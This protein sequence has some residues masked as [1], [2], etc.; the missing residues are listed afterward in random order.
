MELSLSALAALGAAA[1]IGA[2]ALRTAAT[3]SGRNPTVAAGIGAV[4][5]AAGAALFQVPLGFCTF[6]PEATLV[7]LSFGVGLMVVGALLGLRLAWTALDPEAARERVKRSDTTT[8]GV[9]RGHPFLPWLLLAP[10]LTVLVLFLYWPA[11]RTMRLS[12][13]NA[14]LGAP[15]TADRCVTNFTELI[16]PT[17]PTMVLIA[18]VLTVA[19]FAGSSLLKRRG[20]A[21]G[22]RYGGYLSTLG[23]AAA[24]WLLYLLWTTGFQRVYVV[25]LIISAGTVVIGLTLSLAV[26]YLAYRPIRGANIYRTFLVWPYAVSPPIAGLIFF[27]IFDPNAG[28]IEHWLNQLFGVTLPNYRQ[29]ATLAQLVVIVASVWK[30]L[31]YNLLFYIAGLQTVPGDQLEA[32][33]LDGANGW[34]RFRFVVIPALSPIT[35]FLIVTNLT[36]AFFDTFGTIDYL[37]AG[38]PAGQTSVLMYE[39]YRVAIPGR[40]LGRGAAQSMVLFAGVIAL[41]VWQFRSTGRRV[42]YGR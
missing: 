38:G 29:S 40:D 34:Q 19:A 16:G 31:G 32:A 15:R 27:V 39:I 24:L 25:T 6:A 35:F 37:T 41:T 12:T 3:R 4:A 26:A 36:Y 5:C 13:L 9:F 42:S 21:N 20:D 11:V 14:R 1:A 33:E 17:S 2:A 30:T 22:E 18:L 8:H 7:D 28:I 23:V 10:T